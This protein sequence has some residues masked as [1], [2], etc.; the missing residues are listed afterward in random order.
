MRQAEV[1]RMSREG[2]SIPQI[3]ENLKARGVVYKRGGFKRLCTKLGLEPDPQDSVKAIRHHYYNQARRQQKHEFENIATELGVQDVEEWVKS[4]M[5]EEYFIIARRE[6]AHKLMG[7]LRPT[8]PYPAKTK[9]RAQA[10]RADQHHAEPSADQQAA[11][12][13]TDTTPESRGADGP[14]EISDDDTYG[15][16]TGRRL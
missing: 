12:A 16:P 8:H 6:R 13:Q 2:M 9:S 3:E 5:D 4:K 7:D 1:L 10:T 11:S 15:E 14:I